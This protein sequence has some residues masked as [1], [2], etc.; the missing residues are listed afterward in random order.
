MVRISTSAARISRFSL[1]AIFVPAATP[2]TISTFNEGASFVYCH[3]MDIEKTRDVLPGTVV[4]YLPLTIIVWGCHC[5]LDQTF[6][7]SG[8][9]RMTA[10]TAGSGLARDRPQQICSRYLRKRMTSGHRLFSSLEMNLRETVDSGTR[11]TP[12]TP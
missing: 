3:Q 12:A 10:H 4:L 1:A 6:S 9:R 5:C 11:G 7:F 8:E 2:P